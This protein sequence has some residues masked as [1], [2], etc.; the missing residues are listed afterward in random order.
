MIGTYALVSIGGRAVP[1]VTSEGMMHSSVI[2]I[3]GN[4]TWSIRQETQSTWPGSTPTVLIT[5]GTWVLDAR[6]SKIRLRNEG[7][8]G[9]PSQEY[10]V[11]ERGRAIVASTI[12]SGDYRY[13]KQ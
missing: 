7:A 10:D 1:L 2:A 12:S 13:V 9:S 11:R 3:H 4:A 6:A 5:G 8:R